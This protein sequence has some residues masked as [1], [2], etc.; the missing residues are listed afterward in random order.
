MYQ[1]FFTHIWP[2]V[3]KWTGGSG[4]GQP[5]GSDGKNQPAAPQ[6]GLSARYG[7]LF[8]GLLG[9]NM[10]SKA[11]IRNHFAFLTPPQSRGR[12]LAE[13]GAL[14]KD[15]LEKRDSPTMRAYW[16]MPWAHGLTPMDNRLLFREHLEKLPSQ[17]FEVKRK[18]GSRFIMEIVGGKGVHES[19]E[20][21]SV[22]PAWRKTYV[23]CYTVYAPSTSDAEVLRQLA[24]D[25]GSYM[26]EVYI[27]SS[28]KRACELVFVSTLY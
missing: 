19:K 9:N 16:N 13:E 5:G 1:D 11:E 20:N 10:I 6:Y 3:G 12:I 23:S 4:T 28:F 14:G 26:N 24:P 15:H 18:F 21:T 25:S 22:V 17:P 7:A 27:I 2:Q 8:K